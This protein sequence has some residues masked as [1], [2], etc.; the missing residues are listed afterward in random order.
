MGHFIT[1]LNLINNGNISHINP[2]PVSQKQSEPMNKQPV[3]SLTRLTQEEI[4]KYVR[5]SVASTSDHRP[6]DG[7]QLSIE[8][9]ENGRFAHNISAA[10]LKKGKI[11]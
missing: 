3:V 2:N 1:V 9:Y 7:V 11:M 4:N 10:F 6:I 8:N 5:R